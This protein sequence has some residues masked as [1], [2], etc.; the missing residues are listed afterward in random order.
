MD[1]KV[2]QLF[3]EISAK[4]DGNF[5]S[6]IKSAETNVKSLGK[7]MQKSEG[8][9]TSFADKLTN[10][11]KA[12]GLVFLAKQVFDF[13]KTSVQAFANAQQSLIQFN[14][15]QQNVAGS[16]KEQIESLNELVNELERKTSVDDK[17]IRQGAQI[18]AQ[19]QISIEN[20]KKLLQGLVDL[21][22]ANSKANG[23]EVDVAGTSKAIGRAIA[24]GELGAL[25]KQNIVGI[26]ETRIALFKLGNQAE[27]TAIAAELLKENGAGAGE[28]LGRSFQGKVNAAKDTIEGLQVSIGQ[29]L[30]VALIT[31]TGQLSN[32]TT[33]LEVTKGGS[34][35]IG[36]SFVYLA[37][38]I[39]FV[40]NS[41]KLFGQGLVAFGKTA[42]GVANIMIGLGKDALESFKRIGAGISAV[43]DAFVKLKDG[44]V[45]GA[46]E[47]LAGAFDSTGILNNTKE[48]L[49][50]LLDSAVASTEGFKETGIALASSLLIASDAK[51]VYQD[52]KA[53]QDK[54][55]TAET[56]KRNAT[57][58]STE[59]Q[60]EATDE[61][62]KAQQEL[63]GFTKKLVDVTIQSKKTSKELNENL[64]KS[65]KDFS[66]SV[67]DNLNE[68]QKQLADIVL[69]A[70]KK[71]AELLSAT[72][73][74]EEQKVA[75]AKELARVEQV[76]NA[77]VGF[78][79][80][81]NKQIADIRK[82]ITDAG[83]DPANFQLDVN[84]KTLE[85]QIQ[86]ARLDATL[87]EFTLFEQTQ[88]Q[89]LL[90]L[91]NDFITETLLIKNK[92]D[93]QKG[94]ES[95]LTTFLQS[96][97]AIRTEDIQ[98]FA[99]NAI[100]KYKEI[101]ESLRDVI[102]LQDQ[103]GQ[104]SSP[105]AELPKFSAGG[106]VGARGG[107]V[108]PGEFVVPANLVAQNPDLINML[109]RARTQNNNITINAQNTGGDLRTASEDLLWRLGRI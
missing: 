24:T 81:A 22:V 99:A 34:D 47:A 76:L 40:F 70:E 87:D 102:S 33:D 83:L 65:F 14:N 74:T 107:E 32:V 6:N 104:I 5:N 12:A 15:A 89:K 41:V 46:K 108:H 26:D 57:K 7:E 20:Q 48:A 101:A 55:T 92:I 78:E 49:D 64:A 11:A 82:R 67:A 39:A 66:E 3:Y 90:K 25:T 61:A 109:D 29:G 51:K 63:D 58:A 103:V 98:V 28:A 8:K 69:E 27:R 54:L 38:I 56:S 59:A 31:L 50:S 16:T 13:G 30:S 71:K 37:S 80:R 88:N 96:E 43:G 44:D 91:T 95:D 45:K 77:R 72:D 62:K 4:L 68:T 1:T 105:G 106:F 42:F 75:D 18:L 73:R 35:E 10:F 19:D 52:L 9:A 36:K 85:Q 2:G 94:F 86:Q 23:G 21:S 93:V 53:E 17:S 60:A 100:T 79:D 84:Q 97:N